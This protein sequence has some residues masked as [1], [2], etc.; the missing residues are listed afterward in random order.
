MS[1]S[2]AVTPLP[3]KFYGKMEETFPLRNT[4]ISMWHTVQVWLWEDT[5]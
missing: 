4:H 3:F 2:L 1:F 5:K